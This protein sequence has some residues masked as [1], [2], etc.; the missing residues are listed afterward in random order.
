[1]TQTHNDRRKAIRGGG[2]GGGGGVDE[3][4]EETDEWK[5]NKYTIFRWKL[6]IFGENLRKKSRKSSL[7]R[8]RERERESALGWR[9]GMCGS[10]SKP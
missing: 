8:E 10:L 7:D 5:K 2:G 6:L 4:A 9:E 1:M 3:S